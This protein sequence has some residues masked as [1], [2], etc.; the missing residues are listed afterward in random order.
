[1]KNYEQGRVETFNYKAVKNF[2]E[3]YIFLYSHKSDLTGMACVMFEGLLEAF[4]TA[5]QLAYTA[6]FFP[7]EDDEDDPINT[8]EQLRDWLINTSLNTIINKDVKTQEE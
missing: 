4:K 5:S 7:A 2:I 6:D 1:M 3:G 8:E